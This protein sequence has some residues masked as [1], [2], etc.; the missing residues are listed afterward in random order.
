MLLFFKAVHIIGFVSW[1]AALF[2]M[3]RLFI[4]HVEAFDAEEPKR[5]ILVEQFKLMEGR[6]YSIIM[7]PAMFITFIAGFSM[8]Y[9][10]GSAWLEY[11]QWMYYKLFLLAGL[12]GYHH[13]CKRLMRQLGAGER[14]M[15]STQLRL[16]NEVTT[17]FLVAIVLLAIFKN[18]LDF[19]A[20]FAGL[21]AFGVLLGVGVKF[22]KKIRD[23]AD[24]K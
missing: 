15:T 22:Y 11:N 23:R 9:L 20:A 16:F 12:V 6:L 21:I 19:I 13:Y 10:K 5:S 2:Y 24:Q 4:Y 7:T 8:L 17:L 18:A 1:F 14:V 3:P